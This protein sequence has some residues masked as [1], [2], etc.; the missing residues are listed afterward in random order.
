MNKAF[1]AAALCSAALVSTA[2]HADTR[3]DAYLSAAAGFNSDQSADT[4]GAAIGGVAYDLRGSIAMPVQGSNIGVQGDVEISGT[5]INNVGHWGYGAMS[6]P[7]ETAALHAFTRSDRALV[8]LVVQ[9]TKLGSMIYDGYGNRERRFYFGGE[10][11]LYLHNVTLS[12]QATY[13][14]NSGQQFVYDDETY[15]YNSHGVNLAASAKYFLTANTSVAAEGGFESSGTN[16][17]DGP[18]YKHT[19]WLAGTKVEHRLGSL[20]LSYTAEATYR[21][22]VYNNQGFNRD[23]DLRVMV[24]VKLNFGSK[25]LQERDHTGASLETVRPLNDSF[26]GSLSW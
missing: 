11:Q 25:T 24:G 1:F 13:F 3:F 22:G 20:P 16:Y 17:V 9:T 2:A 10:G 15:Q 23:H 4:E 5:P 18:I 21:S 8:G 26:N 7:Q 14:V 12:G 6:D 19:A